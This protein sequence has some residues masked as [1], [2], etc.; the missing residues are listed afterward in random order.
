MLSGSDYKWAALF[1]HAA[2]AKM[3]G[4]KARP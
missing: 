3:S 4:S 2:A 1:K